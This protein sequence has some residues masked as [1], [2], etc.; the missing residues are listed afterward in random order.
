LTFKLKAHASWRAF[1][2]AALIGS[3]VGVALGA[4]YMA[5]GMAR[6][7][8]DQARAS[9]LAEAAAGQFSET[10]LRQEA[11]SMDAGVLQVARRHDPLVQ[12]ERDRQ[13]AA[14]TERLQSGGQAAAHD[15]ARELECLTEAVYFEARGEGA[16]GQAAVAQVVLNRVRHAGFPKTVC[17]VVYQGA[18]RR[19]GCQ[20]S[21]ACDGSLG[22]GHDAAAWRRAQRV[23]TRALSGVVAASIGDATHF[24]TVNVA[25]NWGPNLIRTAQVGLHIFYKLGRGVASTQYAKVEPEVKLTSAPPPAAAVAPK[26][27]KEF[28]LADTAEADVAVKVKAATPVAPAA[29]AAP[30]GEA[31]DAV[32]QAVDAKPV[33]KAEA[34]KL[35]PASLP[36]PAEP[37]VKAPV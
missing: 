17:G 37:M 3:S 19:S 2:G 12:T 9:R 5:G 18:S 29:A 14:L 1:T 15:S 24:H 36:H 21:F 6:A 26:V 16:T 20:F 11:A 31:A 27:T 32:A 4:C 33:T 30:T 23:A 8:D 28:R 25:P 13:L 22:R 35:T 10:A 7:A 34:A